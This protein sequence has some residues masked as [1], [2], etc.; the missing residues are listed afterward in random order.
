MASAWLPRPLDG[1]RLQILSG[2]GSASKVNRV[3]HTDYVLMAIAAPG[4]VRVDADDDPPLR[5]T[6]VAVNPVEHADPAREI[7]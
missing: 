7:V 1:A 5:L 6:V 4:S 3:G 2:A